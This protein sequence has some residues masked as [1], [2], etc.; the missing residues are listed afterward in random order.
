MWTH[1]VVAVRLRTLP[2]A[3]GMNV[4]HF[5]HVADGRLTGH[6]GFNCLQAA[7]LI[8]GELSEIR[9]LRRKKMMSPW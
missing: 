3:T 8:L 7:A 1:G 4:V 2:L 9:C 6:L 5:G